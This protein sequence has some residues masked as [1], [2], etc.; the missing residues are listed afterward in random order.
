METS[1]ANLMQQ[2]QRNI[3][4]P[5]GDDNVARSFVSSEHVATQQL[6]VAVDQ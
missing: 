6:V 4:Q 5:Y 2:M 1:D 3:S